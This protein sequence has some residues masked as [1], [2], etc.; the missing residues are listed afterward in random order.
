MAAIKPTI[1]AYV[2][3]LRNGKVQ[4]GCSRYLHEL[5]LVVIAWNDLHLEL[6]QLFWIVTG[7]S[8]GGVALRIWHST[9][10]DRAQRKMLRETLDSG[11]M[12]L[13]R[14]KEEG[15]A[16]ARRAESDIKYILDK[17][18]RISGPRNDALHS[19]FVFAQEGQKI[20]MEAFDFFKSPRAAALSGKNLLLEFRR[21]RES[22]AILSSFA[23][24]VR[25]ALYLK[26]QPSW[27][28]RPSLPPAA[29]TSMHKG[30]SRGKRAK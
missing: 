12:H 22:S 25:L 16:W 20:T 3:P 5:A 15:P 30:Q 4:R 27:P 29:P 7:I 21:H 2:S 23:Q 8:D 24:R 6:S 9:D 14:A 17:T 10:N 26:P 18:D 28:D 1:T 19:P 13:W 11:L